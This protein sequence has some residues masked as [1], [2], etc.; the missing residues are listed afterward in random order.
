[1]APIGAIL[2][3]VEAFNGA[4]LHEKWSPTEDSFGG[5]LLTTPDPALDRANYLG[6][7]ARDFPKQM[8]T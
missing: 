2:A 1:M 5:Q 3:M 8:A 7:V 6:K 4:I